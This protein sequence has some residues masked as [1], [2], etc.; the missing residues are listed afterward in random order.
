MSDYITTKELCDLL[1]VSRQTL[2][3]W[4]KEGL[5]HEKFGKLVR[6]NKEKVY[7]WLKERK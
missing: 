4:R 7:K 6:F 3:N 5:P 2:T 1:K